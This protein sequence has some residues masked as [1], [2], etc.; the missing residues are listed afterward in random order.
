[1]IKDYKDLKIVACKYEI[2]LETEMPKLLG[3]KSRW[4]LKIALDNPKRREKILKKANE[5]FKKF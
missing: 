1:M 2:K 4:G 5:I 3:Y